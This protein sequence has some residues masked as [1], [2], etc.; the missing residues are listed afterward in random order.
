MNPHYVPQQKIHS[1][2]ENIKKSD[3]KM[4]QLLVE[5][6]VSIIYDISALFSPCWRSQLYQKK[7]K[8]ENG[9]RFPKGH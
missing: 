4:R 7:K 2:L 6:L 1:L 9:L 5:T 3:A 8:N